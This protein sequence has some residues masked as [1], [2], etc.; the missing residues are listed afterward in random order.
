MMM[1]GKNSI[2]YLDVCDKY[3][4]YHEVPELESRNI[5]SH[6]DEEASLLIWFSSDSGSSDQKTDFPAKFLLIK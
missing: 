4:K 3:I 1:A 5:F 6:S 2:E